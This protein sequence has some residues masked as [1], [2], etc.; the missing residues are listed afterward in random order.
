MEINLRL[1]IVQIRKDKSS[2]LLKTGKLT[3][4][5][6]GHVKSK[7]PKPMLIGCILGVWVPNIL[8]TN[9]F[10]EINCTVVYTLLFSKKV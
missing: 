3:G 10:V 6:C 2:R 9:T 1:L 7:P 5:F 4:V 8:Q